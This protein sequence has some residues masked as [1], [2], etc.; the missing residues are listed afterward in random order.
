[1]ATFLII[2][3]QVL[4]QVLSIMV[5]ADAILSFFL[6]PYHTIREALGRILNPLYAPIRRILPAMGGFDLS[7]II[8][9]LLIQAVV[10]ILTGLFRAL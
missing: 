8:L 3:I 4:A 2:L 10:Y 6:S 1:M 9:L 7:P 5:I